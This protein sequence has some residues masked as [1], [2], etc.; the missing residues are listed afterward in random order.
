MGHLY[1]Q[2]EVTTDG[3]YLGETL[4]NLYGSDYSGIDTI[5]I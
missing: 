4:L 2:I 3:V 5:L 1:V